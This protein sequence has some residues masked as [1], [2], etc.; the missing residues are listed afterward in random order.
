MDDKIQTLT[1]S[2]YITNINRGDTTNIDIDDSTYSFRSILPMDYLGRGNNTTKPTVNVYKNDLS[3][4]NS[5][6]ELDNDSLSNNSSDDE[7]YEN[8]LSNEDDDDKRTQDIIMN[9]HIKRDH[10]V[11]KD[12]PMKN[13]YI[14]QFY[15]SSITVVGLFVLYRMLQRK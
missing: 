6:F 10:N 14:C 11:K 13:D 5:K 12:V 15:V 2:E 1:Y 9:E 7:L 8:E 4:N 3:I